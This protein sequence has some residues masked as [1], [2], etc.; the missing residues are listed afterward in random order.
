MEFSFENVLATAS[1]VRFVEPSLSDALK[2]SW[3]FLLFLLVKN[4]DINLI[5]SYISTFKLCV[6]PLNK[7]P[8]EFLCLKVIKNFFI[9]Y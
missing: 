7:L 5:L 1:Q 3:A 6:D 9:Y 8:F 2:A 4:I